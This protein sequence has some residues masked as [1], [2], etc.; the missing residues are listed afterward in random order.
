[1]KI[2]HLIDRRAADAEALALVAAIEHL[3]TRTA[4]AEALALA[5]VIEHLSTRTANDR[6]RS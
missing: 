5:A 3:S 4:D 2:R 1:M 6:E